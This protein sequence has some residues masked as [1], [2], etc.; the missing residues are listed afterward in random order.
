MKVT[1]PRNHFLVPGIPRYSRTAIKKMKADEKAGKRVK[2]TCEKK[3]TKAPAPRKKAIQKSKFYPAEKSPQ[4]KRYRKSKVQKTPK[5]RSSITPGTILIL[6]AGRHRGKRVVFLKQ[7]ASG[8]LLVTGP[9]YLNRVP[10]RRVNQAYVMATSTRLELNFE[11]DAK[12]DDKYFLR[13]VQ[14]KKESKEEKF[15]SKKN[16]KLSFQLTDSR[17]KDQK[18]VDRLIQPL[19]QQVDQLKTYLKGKFS[20]SRRQFPHMMKF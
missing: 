16:S 13:M 20:L 12:F 8:L 19:V 18:A 17:R 7:L 15:F 6:L 4:P 11:V 10:L 1:V 9:Y 2:Q 3:Q 5:L 14:K